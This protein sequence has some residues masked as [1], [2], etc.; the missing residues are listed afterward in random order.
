MANVISFI[1]VNI[2][3]EMKTVKPIVDHLLQRVVI[4]RSLALANQISQ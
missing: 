3:G 1:Q 4:V 2:G